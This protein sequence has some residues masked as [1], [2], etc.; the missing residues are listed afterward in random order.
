MWH[1]VAPH[2]VDL[3]MSPLCQRHVWP[4]E[5]TQ[6]APFYP[7]HVRVC[8]RCF[9]VQLEAYVRPQES[10]D[11]YAYSSSYSDRALADGHIREWGGQFVVP[12]PE[13]RICP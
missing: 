11:D 10:F 8:D 5:L 3:G 2:I 7:L 4:H 13:T 6:M 12:V 9:L 1:A